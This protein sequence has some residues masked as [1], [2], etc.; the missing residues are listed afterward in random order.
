MPGS[1]E[2]FL[3]PVDFSDATA[4]ALE[5][6]LDM[7]KQA[8]SRLTLLHVIETIDDEPDDELD[9]FY[10]DLERQAESRLAAMA[11]RFSDTGVS[12]SHEIVFGNR[13]REIVRYSSERHVD[14]VVMRSRRMDLQQP[15]DHFGS[16]SHQVSIFCQCPVL[17]L[18]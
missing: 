8:E 11:K 12:V 5:R 10:K 17:L 13:A 2:H 3:V 9:D 16:V 6:I 1:F 15:T 4:D 14:L 18:K 7:V